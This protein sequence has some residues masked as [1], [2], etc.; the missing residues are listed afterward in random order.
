MPEARLCDFTKIELSIPYTVRIRLIKLSYKQTFLDA[1]EL[2][3]C[4]IWQW[5]A[6][7]IIKKALHLRSISEKA[8]LRA[9]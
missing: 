8:L 1:D 6:D 5:K 2:M 4:K 7:M 3:F 9:K